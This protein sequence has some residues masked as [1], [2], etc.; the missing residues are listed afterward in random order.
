MRGVYG[1]GLLAVGMLLTGCDEGG[2]TNAHTERCN[3]VK[4]DEQREGKAFMKMRAELL[5][6]LERGLI[7]TSATQN[8]DVVYRHV[9]AIYK[10][11]DAQEF[12]QQAAAA[13]S[14]IALIYRIILNDRS[15]FTPARVAK[16][17]QDAETLRLC[18]NLSDLFGT[19]NMHF[20][21]GSDN[22]L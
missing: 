16:T 14:Q 22:S 5:H 10:A 17:Q 11:I 8:R 21:S 1:A 2:S 19:H 4:H 15:C 12:E 18:A 6:M 3:L 13:R 9:T 20:M 7:P